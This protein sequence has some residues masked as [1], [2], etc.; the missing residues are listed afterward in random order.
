MICY[1][2]KIQS[3]RLGKRALREIHSY[4][5]VSGLGKVTLPDVVIRGKILLK[6]GVHFQMSSLQPDSDWSC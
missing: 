3:D 2:K 4:H 1:Y 5:F 6:A